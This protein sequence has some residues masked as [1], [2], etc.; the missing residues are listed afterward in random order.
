MSSKMLLTNTVAVLVF[1]F[2]FGATLQHIHADGDACRIENI[3]ENDDYSVD[4]S[5]SDTDYSSPCHWRATCITTA[6][7]FQCVCPDGYEGDGINSCERITVACSELEAPEHGS[8]SKVGTLRVRF[9]CDE[10]YTLYGSPLRLCSHGNWSGRQPYCQIRVIGCGHPGELENGQILGSDFDFGRSVRF[11]CNGDHRLIGPNR[12]ECLNTGYWTGYQ[13]FCE[14]PRDLNDIASAIR[15][16]FIDKLEFFSSSSRGHQG[17]GRLSVGGSLGLDLIFAF[18]RS[19]SIDPD[20]FERGMDFAKYIIDEFGVSYEA[21]GTRVAA[22]SFASEARI[23]FN[24]GDDDV[25]T[26]GKAKRRINI[27]QALGGGTAM[28]EAFE[29]IFSDVVPKIREGA[30]QAL[31]I[32]TDGKSNSGSPVAFAKRLR[33]EKDFE[34]FAIGVGDGVDRDELK[35]IASEPFT[36]H[37]FLITQYVDLTTLTEIIAEKRTDYNRCGVAGD[38]EQAQLPGRVVGGDEANRGAWPW[39]AAIYQQHK[40]RGLIFTCGGAL[41]CEN[42]VLT[43]AH[44]LERN[45]RLLRPHK[46]IVRLGEHERGVDEGCEQTIPVLEYKRPDGYNAETL[47]YDVA[48]LRLAQPAK[49]VSC[50]RT[51]CLPNELD[52]YTTRPNTDNCYI[53]GWG[54]TNAADDQSDAGDPTL[55]LR[56]LIMPLVSRQDCQQSSETAITER[57]LCAGFRYKARDACK[58]DS[59][60]ALVCRRGD[61]S[62]AAI[63]IVSRGDGCAEANKYSIYTDVLEVNDWINEITENC[64]DEYVRDEDEILN[65]IS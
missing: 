19:S 50:V 21:G 57:M 24:L 33:Q 9:S 6:D 64:N 13:P 22:V 7:S 32:I 44:C 42:W 30:K 37:V 56:Q 18:D 43:A 3:D 11:V 14:P 36:T 12:R 52:R 4:P 59:G 10:G 31:F 38:I 45:G 29:L 46:L 51:L 5:Y 34:T 39:V 61:D 55:I 49:L 20:D 62:F 26:A 65:P 15:H 28:K 48:L 53:T 47:D 40:S 27:I 25:N 54:A 35:K 8:M 63:G 16:D 41:I 17:L 60:G 58:G 1:I 2:T 23:E